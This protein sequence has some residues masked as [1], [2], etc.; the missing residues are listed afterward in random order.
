MISM[1][2]THADLNIKRSIK[3]TKVIATRHQMEVIKLCYLS[4]SSHMLL[5][6]PGVVKCPESS[7]FLSCI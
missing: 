6:Y 1:D 7:S 5:V 2:F 4:V 3:V